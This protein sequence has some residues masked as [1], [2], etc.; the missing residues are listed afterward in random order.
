MTMRPLTRILSAVGARRF[1]V[2][3][4]GIEKRNIEIGRK[5]GLMQLEGERGV[6]SEGGAMVGWWITV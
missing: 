3:P 6:L 1:A 5:R 2:Q 4:P